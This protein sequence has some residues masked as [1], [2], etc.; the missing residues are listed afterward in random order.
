M[1]PVALKHMILA[2]V[3]IDRSSVSGGSIP[4]FY[5]NNDSELQQICIYL[6]RVLDG[7]TH[8]LENGTCFIVKH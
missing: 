3:T 5:A 8:S 4:T 1:E 7:F 6:S 2:I